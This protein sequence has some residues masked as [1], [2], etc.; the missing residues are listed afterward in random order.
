MDTISNT[1]KKRNKKIN[2]S[3]ETGNDGKIKH[4]IKT[5]ILRFMIYQ[6]SENKKKYNKKKT[7]YNYHSNMNETIFYMAEIGDI[8]SN[9]FSNYAK[10]VQI[11]E[12][13]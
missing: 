3:N 5:T 4:I 10:A 8:F 11:N 12:N 13:L 2:E 6:E 1:N 7:L 9:F